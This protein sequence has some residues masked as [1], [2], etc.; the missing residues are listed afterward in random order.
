MLLRPDKDSQPWEGLQG[1]DSFFPYRV[2]NRWLGFY[3]SANTEHK[4]IEHWRVGLV[5]A[6]QLAGPWKRYAGTNPVKEF[7]D[8]NVG[9]SFAENPI[10]TRLE[11]GGYMTMFDNEYPNG[12][13][14]SWSPDGLHWMWGKNLVLQPKGAS[15]WADRI[16]TPL[17]LVAEGN[18]LFTLFYTGYQNVLGSDELRFEAIGF[19]TLKLQPQN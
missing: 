8:F 18:S 3:G 9:K 7:S 16:R 17:G 12:I 1:T 13:G 4:P 15:F 14:Y 6:A 2:G 19:V 10:V 11:D 5:E